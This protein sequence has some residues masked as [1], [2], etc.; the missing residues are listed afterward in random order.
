MNAGY[1]LTRAANYYPNHTAFVIDDEAMTYKDLNERVN[2][3]ANALLDL[4]LKKGDR[5]GLLFHNSYG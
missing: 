4:G 1:L 2:K 3:L 5:V